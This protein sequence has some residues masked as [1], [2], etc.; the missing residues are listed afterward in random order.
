VA[1]NYLQQALQIE[2]TVKKDFSNIASSHLN[3]CAILSQLD[4]H[5]QALEHA[6]KAVKYI[7]R[8]ISKIKNQIKEGQ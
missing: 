1:L 5:P 4:R 7:E 2:K 6:I 8:G 3:I